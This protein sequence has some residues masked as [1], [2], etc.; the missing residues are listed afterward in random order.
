[1]LKL[2]DCSMLPALTTS[3]P[4]AAELLTVTEN[5]PS[6]LICVTSGN[7]DG[8]EED[9][10]PDEV[11]VLAEVILLKKGLGVE[12]GMVGLAV[13]S[14]NVTTAARGTP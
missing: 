2:M 6:S 11:V 3:L 1:M 7:P 12:A 8:R 10:T 5:L 13:D 4:L 9:L 14:S